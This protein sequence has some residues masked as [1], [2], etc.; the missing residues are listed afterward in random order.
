MVNKLALTIFI[1]VN[2][3]FA[4]NSIRD[5]INTED[6]RY[7][8][9]SIIQLIVNP[10]KYDGK[11]ISV[12]GYMH[13]KFEDCAIYLTKTDAD[14]LNGANGLWI[15]FSKNIEKLSINSGYKKSDVPISY[16]DCKFVRITGIFNMNERGHMGM[17]A[18]AIDSVQNISEERQ[19]Y[20]GGKELWEDKVDGKGLVPQNQ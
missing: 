8:D 2:S 18:G 15:S 6:A 19:W 9:I 12:S 14:Y 16:F 4:Q 5:T 17:F 20:N 1:L 7:S 10:V 11:K 3:L 13:I